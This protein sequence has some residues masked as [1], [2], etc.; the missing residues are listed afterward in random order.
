MERS[1]VTEVLMDN[2]TTFHPAAL[3]EILEG[4]GGHFF[5]AADR[6]SGNNGVERHH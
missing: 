3:K 6:P 2:D 5:R 1:P 4:V